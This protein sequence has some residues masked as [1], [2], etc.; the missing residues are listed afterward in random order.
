MQKPLLLNCPASVVARACYMGIAR[1]GA[2]EKQNREH[3]FRGIHQKS[4]TSSLNPDCALVHSTSRRRALL[5]IR[6]STGTSATSATRISYF[7]AF[8][9]RKRAK[10]TLETRRGTVSTCLQ[11][12]DAMPHNCCEQFGAYLTVE[13]LGHT[14]V[15]DSL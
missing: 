9:K 5:L 11:E 7:C 1:R 15:P 12:H 2:T 3:V 8:R 6:S 4:H 10:S 13:Q 14:I